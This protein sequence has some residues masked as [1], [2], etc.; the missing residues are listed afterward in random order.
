MR[1]LT[2]KERIHLHLFDYSR[3]SD[4]YEAPPEVTQEAI[5]RAAGIRVQ[6]VVQYVRPLMADGLVEERLAHVKRARRRHKT[7]FLTPKG[8]AQAA[9]PRPDLLPEEIPIRGPAGP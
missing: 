8:R 2:A 9:A 7:Y 5:A 1:T 3:F 4:A 6:H